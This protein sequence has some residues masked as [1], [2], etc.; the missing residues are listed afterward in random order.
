MSPTVQLVE[1]K[2]LKRSL[3]LDLD[4][5]WKSDCS[6]TVTTDKPCII[7]S[8]KH[9]RLPLFTRV[10]MYLQNSNNNQRIEF[11]RKI[12]LTISPSEYTVRW[13]Y[14]IVCTKSVVSVLNRCIVCR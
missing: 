9:F 6:A 14:R 5:L 1:V 8:D 12:S 11:R 3:I 13:T 7:N 10:Y 2:E 4:I